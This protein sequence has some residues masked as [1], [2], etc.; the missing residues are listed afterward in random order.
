MLTCTQV[1]H[2]LTCFKDNKA[3]NCKEAVHTHRVDGEHGL[4]NVFITFMSV[5]M[6]HLYVKRQLSQAT[7]EKDLWSHNIPCSPAAVLCTEIQ[8]CYDTECLSAC[9]SHNISPSQ[10]DFTLLDFFLLTIVKHLCVA[11]TYITP[12]IFCDLCTCVCTHACS[13][14]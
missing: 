9:S 6:L 2:I 12:Y 7:M 3:N 13:P 10:T 4:N 14:S 1:Q 8:T 11:Y 5:F